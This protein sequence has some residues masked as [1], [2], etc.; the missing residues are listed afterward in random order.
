MATY[1]NDSAQNIYYHTGTTPSNT[2]KK[3]KYKVSYNGNVIAPGKKVSVR[4]P[5][6]LNNLFYYIS[7][8]FF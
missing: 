7:W 2:A 8:K 6:N 5:S 3:T 4:P 1:F